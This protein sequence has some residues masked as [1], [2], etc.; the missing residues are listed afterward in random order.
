MPLYRT[1]SGIRY[2]R[3]LLEA[4][5]NHTQGRGE[6]RLSLEEVQDLFRLAGDAQRIT[7][8]EWR[9]LHYIASNYPLPDLSDHGF[10]VVIP[11]WPDDDQ[12]P[13]VYGAN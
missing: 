5:E 12:L 1:I 11:R 13:Y 10:W 3:S 4:A 8:T 6:S 2:D 7:E 9:T